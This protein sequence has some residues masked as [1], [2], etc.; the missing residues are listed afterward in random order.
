MPRAYGIMDYTSDMV[1]LRYA[2]E[3]AVRSVEVVRWTREGRADNDRAGR[4]AYATL[5]RVRKDGQRQKS[6]GQSAYEMGLILHMAN[7]DVKDD[8]ERRI[9][10]RDRSWPSSERGRQTLHISRCWPQQASMPCNVA[11]SSGS[12]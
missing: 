10:K 11:Y 9:A 6:K 4:E 12:S 2:C 7:Q 1:G 5:A 3:L 8:N